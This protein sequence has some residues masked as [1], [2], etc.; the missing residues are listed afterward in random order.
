[1]GW[2]ILVL[3][4]KLQG[5]SLLGLML[6]RWELLGLLRSRLWLGIFGVDKL[7]EYKQQNNVLNNE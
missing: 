4:S 2:G 5:K 3:K 1:M 6:R 7:L